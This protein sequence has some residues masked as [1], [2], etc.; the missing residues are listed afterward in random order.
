MV[1]VT[2]GRT[3]NYLLYDAIH[4]KNQQTSQ[5]SNPPKVPQKPNSTVIGLLMQTV[6]YEL[7]M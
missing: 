2:F 1:M 4:E 7:E 5:E 3:I 6:R